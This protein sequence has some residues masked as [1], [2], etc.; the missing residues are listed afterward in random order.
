[1]FGPAAARALD[2][3]VG[4]V[5]PTTRP[6]RGGS[7]SCVLGDGVMDAAFWDHSLQRVAIFS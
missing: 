7:F 4:S 3:A 2:N 5:A 1:M 6:S